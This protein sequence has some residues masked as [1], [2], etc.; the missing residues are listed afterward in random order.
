VNTL[1]HATDDTISPLQKLRL[2]SPSGVKPPNVSRIPSVHE[3]QIHALVQQLFFCRES[4]P[5][6]HVGV[7]PVDASTS[8]AALCFEA[9]ETLAKE[10]K[11]DVA[12]I[13]A[14]PTSTLLQTELHILSPKIEAPS[15]PIAPHLWIVPRVAWLPET[16]NENISDESLSRLQEIT[17]EFDFS[18]LRL[19]PISWKTLR[20]SRACD[21][22]ALV[23]TANKTRRLVATQIK[24]QLSRA[25]VPLLGT[26]LADRRFPLPEGLYR[27]L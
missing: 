16:E 7:A 27:N 26:I 6:R 15:W 23:L 9:A 10:K 25:N 11:Y 12:V 19:G 14:H 1:A 8:T 22:L 17:L 5:V 3:L 13:D 24:E 18:V 20:I 4:K 21:G 2:D